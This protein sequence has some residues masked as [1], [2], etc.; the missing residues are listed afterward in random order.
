MRQKFFKNDSTR[1]IR[2]LLVLTMWPAALLAEDTE[3]LFYRPFAETTH[4]PSLIIGRNVKGHCRQQS[5][6]IVREDAWQCMA[7]GKMYDPCFVKRFGPN[8]EAVCTESPWAGQGIKI[9]VD[10]PL[11]D[12]MHKSLDISKA[13]P[14]A[15]ELSHGEH[16][17][18][19][20]PT[21]VYDGLDVHYHCNNE[22]TLF[23]R[24]Q[25]CATTWTVLQRTSQ[26]TSTVE[27]TKAWF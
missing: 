3:L 14:W 4:H 23:G 10:M 2:R 19:V 15:I 20:V 17:L 11:D 6:L 25:R 13:Y 21:E 1:W 9:T 12:R 22:A 24:I 18:A 27:I 7:E 8:N 5:Q 16:C 26:G